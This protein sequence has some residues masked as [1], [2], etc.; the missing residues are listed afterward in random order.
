MPVDEPNTIDIICE[1]RDGTIQLIVSDHL[2]FDGDA[3]HL[4]ILQT[5]LNAYLRF[6]ESGEIYQKYPSALD[7]TVTVE[8]VFFEKPDRDAR[9]F[10]LKA[11]EIFDSAGFPLTH[12]VFADSYDN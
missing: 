6:L 2:P 5:K 3:E 12:K 9:L 10:L 4:L 11:A 1:K 7:R 8:I